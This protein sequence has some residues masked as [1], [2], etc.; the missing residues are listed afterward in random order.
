[1]TEGHEKSIPQPP[2]PPKRLFED[3]D[4]ERFKIWKDLVFQEQTWFWQRFAGFAAMH[5]ALFVV[6]SSLKQPLAVLI[7]ICVGFLFAVLWWRVQTLSL[8]YVDRYKAGF[9]AE[10]ERLLF[11]HS[12]KKPAYVTPAWSSTDLAVSIPL[13]TIVAWVMI[14]LNLL[15]AR[16]P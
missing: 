14:A 5:A 11:Q 8:W 3:E 9:H 10:R 6:V 12:G 4:Y 7:L 1:M 13:V 2:T 15:P 16:S